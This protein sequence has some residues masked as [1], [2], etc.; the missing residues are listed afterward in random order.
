MKN[1]ILLLFAMLIFS[2]VSS[3]NPELYRMWYLYSYSSD[4]GGTHFV[5]EIEPPISPNLAIG[6]NLEFDGQA[7]CSM[8][9]GDFTYDTDEDKLILNNFDAT[10]SQCD[11]QSHNDFENDY[12]GYFTSGNSYSYE[13]EYG[14][15]S[16]D[17]SLTLYSASGFELVYYEHPL[18]VSENKK[19]AINIYPNPVSDELYIIS[20]KGEIKSISIFSTSG[21][22]VLEESKFHK[23]IDVSGLS[24]GIY[25]MEIISYEGRSIQKFIKN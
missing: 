1:F 21:I 13:I 20:E 18:S 15:I 25:F 9:I 11:F 17:Y 22:K 24:K 19:I 14:P 16:E 8:Y 7:A 12:F 2:K 23:S 5:N 4:V 6:S 10:L 3:Q